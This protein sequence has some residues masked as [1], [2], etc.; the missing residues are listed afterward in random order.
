M[1]ENLLTKELGISRTPVREALMDLERA[2]VVEII[3]QYGSRISLIDYS[4]I[5]QAQ[6]CRL[7]V[8]KEIV[9]LL[10]NLP[11]G[12]SFKELEENLSLQEFYQTHFNPSKLMEMDN[13][14]HHQMFRLA[15]KELCYEWL[16][17]GMMVN[18]DRVRS[19]SFS[20]VKNNTTV[21]EHAQL[22]QALKTHDGEK[23][24]SL[25]TYHLS[26]YKQDKP[27]VL[28]LDPSYFKN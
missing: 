7:S 17:K 25:I 15:G 18:F 9:R 5:D 1:S 19:I 14:F 12:T 20:V 21:R 22:L 28:K 27:E 16:F 26:R 11:E 8:E 6:F 24:E 3:P 2:K 4:V 13:E 23:A 10:V